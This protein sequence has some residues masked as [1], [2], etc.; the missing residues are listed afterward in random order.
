MIGE[1]IEHKT[2]RNF[3]LSAEVQILIALRYYATGTF[4]VCIFHK[5]KYLLDIPIYRYICI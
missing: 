1:N 3:S 2:L 4:Q 5:H